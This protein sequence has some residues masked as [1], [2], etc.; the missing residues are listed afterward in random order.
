MSE[1]VLEDS[2]G[3]ATIDERESDLQAVID[4][5]LRQEKA[6]KEDRRRQHEDEVRRARQERQLRDEQLREAI[7]VIKW[8]VVG[9]CA[10]MVL[11]V[12][13]GVWALVQVEQAVVEVERD[14]ENVTGRVDDILHEVEHPF[15][16]AGRLLGQ[17]LD[18]SIS[19]LLG[20][21]DSKSNNQ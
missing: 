2:A 8:C 17:D 20:L 18:S 5:V 3:D 12:V 16:G 6:R 10:A 21:P 7:Q 11:A 4:I 13:L 15:E 14:I 19:K 1:S 9:I